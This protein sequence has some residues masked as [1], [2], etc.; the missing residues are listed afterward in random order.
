MALGVP[1]AQSPLTAAYQDLSDNASSNRSLAKEDAVT[2]PL[3]NTLAVSSVPG[4]KGQPYLS[5]HIANSIKKR[6]W[7]DQFIDLAYLLETQLVPEDSK[8]LVCML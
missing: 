8:S 1:S 2:D 3:V 5:L 4:I 7:V 6:V